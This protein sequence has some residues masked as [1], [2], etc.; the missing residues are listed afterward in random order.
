MSLK[1]R[2]F[3]KPWQHRDPEVRAR[4]VRDDDSP[5]LKTRL[6]ELAQHDDSVQVRLAALERIDTEPFWLDARLRES[7]PAICARADRFILRAVNTTPAEGLL[8]AR[9]DWLERIDEPEI[10][11]RLAA[12]AKD[13]EL[14]RA[15]LSRISSQGFLGDCYATEADAGLAEEILQRIEQVSTLERLHERLRKTSKKRAGAVKE[16]LLEL[17]AASGTLDRER[18]AAESLV[19]RAEAL[20]RGDGETDRAGALEE[21]RRLWA[22]IES[23]DEGLSRRYRGAVSI[24]EASLNRPPPAPPA[25]PSAKEENPDTTDQAPSEGLKRASEAIRQALAGP[26]KT[27]RATA[28]LADW[29]R[30]WNALNPPGAADLAL[31][32]A[33]LPRLR[34]LQHRIQARAAA[35]SK[36]ASTSEPRFDFD[37]ELDATANAIEQGDIASAHAAIGRL[38]SALRKLP[39]KQRPGAVTGRLQRLDGRLK[40][41]RNYQHWSHNEHRDQLIAQ[42]E[43]LAGSGQHPDA[44]SAALKDARQEWQRLDELEI[45][46]GDKRKFAAPAG[47]W[48][49]FQA[50]CK[51]AF[52]S[53]KPYF[54]KRQEVQQDS[55]AELDRFIEQGLEKAGQE[56]VEARVLTPIL[57]KARQAIR[58]LDELPP[59][60]RGASAGRLRELMDQITKK[61]D[62]A[63]EKVELAKRRLVGEAKALAH[64]KDLKAA[65]DKAK[66]LQ[67]QWQRLGSAR[68][69]VDQQLWKEFRE[70]IDPLFAQLDDQRK[71]QKQADK[72]AMA[73]LEALCIQAEA[74]AELPGDELAEASGRM[75]GLADEFA[76]KQ[77]RPGRLTQRFDQARQRFEQRQ[78]EQRMEQQLAEVRA[79]E[80][81][82]SEI[83]QGFEQRMNG[84]P[85]EEAL[86]E[87]LAADSRLSG[88]EALRQAI[89]RIRDPDQTPEQ[90]AA[91][92]SENADRARQVAVEIEF[93]SGMESPAEDRQLRMDHQVQRLASRLAERASQPDLATELSALEAR[94]LASLPH[95]GERHAALAQRFQKC[96]NVVKKMTGIT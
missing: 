49:R 54:E 51:S 12:E 56:D 61:L 87:D 92:A 80:S 19:A 86:P 50:A 57:R 46:P 96:Q 34:E 73:E 82:A 69:K 27:D 64:E 78:Q 55:L 4:A 53:A 93:L 38:R 45:L 35:S 72:E 36:P 17:Q 16:R 14:R 65:I 6:P 47:Q 11:R 63:S 1:S 37:A 44:I 24:I 18:L 9:L 29:D 13:V 8:Q 67:A 32:E 84:T 91:W 25:E 85:A 71:E 79:L 59:K 20:A 30:A 77:T 2:L 7:D 81:L 39:A 76:D 52:D 42:V 41:L 74:L 66:S 62:E 3:K 26:V 40:E 22:G 75:Q 94:W 60:S 21:I 33:T 90:L 28:L 10:F 5:E 48:R 68:R 89:E 83:Q 23:A 15:A 88:H 70:P 43:A 95:P 31:K 58:R